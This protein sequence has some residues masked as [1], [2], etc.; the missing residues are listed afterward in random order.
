MLSSDPVPS[1]I[2][3]IRN[4][5]MGGHES[6]GLTHRLEP[7]HSPL[8]HP[9]RLVRLLGPVVLILLCTVDRFRDK[10]PMSDPITS[11]FISY[12]LSGFSSMGSQ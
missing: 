4:G 6:L 10:L 3:E 2:E 11:Q 7:P 12:Y 1:Q 5:G 8:S 9:G